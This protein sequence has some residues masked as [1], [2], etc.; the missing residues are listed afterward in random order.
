VAEKRTIT[1]LGILIIILVLMILV[2]SRQYEKA[3]VGF[4]L[5]RLWEGPSNEQKLRRCLKV[6]NLL[7][8]KKVAEMEKDKLKAWQYEGMIKR[9]VEKCPSCDQFLEGMQEK[10]K[11]SEAD[12]S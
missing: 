9:H 5:R 4:W 11:A 6:L 2:R 1:R 3:V 10:S 12:F 8:E 7:I